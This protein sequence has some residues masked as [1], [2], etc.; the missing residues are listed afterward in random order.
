MQPFNRVTE[1][2]KTLRADVKRQGFAFLQSFATA[3]TC[4]YIRNFVD[5]FPETDAEMN[6]AGT[7][8]RIWNSHSV[9]PVAEAFGAL[10]DQVMGAVFNSPCKART[11]LAYSNFPI[12]PEQSLTTGRWHIDSLR[13]QYKLFCFLTRT[14]VQTGPLELIPGTHRTAFKLWAI[15]SGQYVSISDWGKQTRRYQSLNEQWAE[16]RGRSA[17]G[18]VPLLCEPGTLIL[19]DTSAIHRARPCLEGNR[20]VLAA[21]Y[22][23]F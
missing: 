5:R 16:T 20:Y 10:C 13:H 19:V 4:G 17:G 21:Y 18:S 11:V 8:K 15:A 22:D 6:Y 9:D 2:V 23:H 14:R 3:E 12:R 1:D 7:E